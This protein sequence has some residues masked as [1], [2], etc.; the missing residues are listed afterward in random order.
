[1]KRELLLSTVVHVV[2]FATLG[3]I[4]ALGARS[5]KQRPQVYQVRLVSAG[6]PQPVTQPE[7]A[8]VVEPK[9][10]AEVR[11]ESKPKPQPPKPKASSDV[12]RRQGLGARV[13]GAQALGYSYYLNVI[14]ARISESW[15]NPYAGQSRTLVATVYFVIER[16]G[17][18]TEVKLEKGS[19]DAAYD[20]SCTRAL[21][22]TEKLP[23]LPP[24]FKGERL[25]LHLEFEYKP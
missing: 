15:L 13:E 5:P 8:Q 23:E 2:L 3:I 25:K 10:K 7:K 6:T 4:S 20:A 22:V 18:I 24:E 19:G 9:P 21:F 14:L 16:D 1:M 11:P 17:R 12:I